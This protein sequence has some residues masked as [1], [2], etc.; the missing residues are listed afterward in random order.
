VAAAPA[1]AEPWIPAAGHGTTKPMVRLFSANTSFPHTNF[2]NHTIPASKETMTQLRLTGT[3]GVGYGLALNYDL[4][5]GTT[6]IS[7][8]GRSV[9][10]SGLQDEEIGLGYG[11]TQTRLFADAIELNLVIPAGQTKP[12]PAQGTG[13]WAVEP[14]LDL[15]LHYGAFGAT[16]LVGPRIFLDGNA[17]QF[18]T[19]LDLAAHATPR[20]TFTG[21]V[22]FVDTAQTGS[23][24]P[25][26][27]S[28]ELY[29][30]LRLGLGVEYRLT[31]S[32]RPF[33]SYQDYVAG[34]GIHAGN[35][36]EIGLVVKY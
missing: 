36:I 3:T 28:G 8:R 33:F 25:P 9:T 19:E 21:S 30:L 32:L 22:F 34:K 6:Q 12:A 17:I 24:P 1:W 20:L 31:D 35:R 23:V 4:R 14:D 15:G 26:G 13:R 10:T 2:T 16:L 7:K 18:R 29:N 11:L 27:A 5:W